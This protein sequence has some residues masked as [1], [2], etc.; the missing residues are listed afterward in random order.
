MIDSY[1]IR[2]KQMNKCKMKGADLRFKVHF[3]PEQRCTDIGLVLLS[4]TVYYQ[5]VN[6]RLN[7]ILHCMT[8]ISILV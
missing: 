7:Y 5:C 8:L 1:V 3:L 6:K 2:N 4:R